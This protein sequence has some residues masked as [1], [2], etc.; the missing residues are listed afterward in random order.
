M[1]SGVGASVKSLADEELAHLAIDSISNSLSTQ[2]L[3]F[4]KEEADCGEWEIASWF[5]AD[6]G[7]EAGAKIPKFIVDELLLRWKST[8]LPEGIE[9]LRRA[10]GS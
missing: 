8:D 10:S 4:C 9:A 3:S 2:Q 6:I 7:N 1:V 5:A